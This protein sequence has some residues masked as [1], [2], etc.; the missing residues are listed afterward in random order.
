MLCEKPLTRHP[1]DA[2]AAFDAADRAGRF[3]SEAFMYRHNPQTA[4]VVSLV[5]VGGDRRA[6]GHP[7]D[8]QLLA[9]RP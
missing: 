5:R 4:R 3:L 9:V 1:D 6:A 7:L 2:V 8:V